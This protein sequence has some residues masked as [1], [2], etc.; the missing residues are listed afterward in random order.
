ILISSLFFGFFLLRAGPIGFQY[1]AELTY[2]APEGASNGM[3][4]LVGQIS[5]IA[6]ILALDAFKSPETGTMTAPLAVMIGLMVISIFLT[7]LLKEP[8]NLMIDN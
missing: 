7:T 1:G 5:G 8:R 4:L 6:F 2:P 3:M